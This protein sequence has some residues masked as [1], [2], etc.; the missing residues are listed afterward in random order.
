MRDMQL[1]QL[2]ILWCRHMPH[3]CHMLLMISA[4]NAACGASIAQKHVYTL[5]K[6]G[7]GV[8]D[9]EGPWCASASCI[10]ECR[11]TYLLAGA[12]RLY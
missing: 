5:V 1:E 8:D 12:D 11:I 6:D 2:L 7:I 10:T 3:D 9:D 4:S